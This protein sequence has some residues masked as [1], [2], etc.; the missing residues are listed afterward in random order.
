MDFSGFEREFE[1]LFEIVKTKLITKETDEY[2][3]QVLSIT[4]SDSKRFFAVMKEY[5]KSMSELAKLYKMRIGF[6]EEENGAKNTQIKRLQYLLDREN[7]H[8]SEEV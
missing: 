4:E 1:L 3:R 5:I 6:L 7:V 2:V 8:L